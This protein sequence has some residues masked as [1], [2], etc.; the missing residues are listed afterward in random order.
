MIE[1]A[2]TSILDYG[3]DPTGS[4]DSTVA[5]QTAINVVGNYT[6]DTGIQGTVYIPNGS[7]KITAPI[8]MG[9][10]VMLVGNG[11]RFA[12]TFVPAAT[13][14][15]AALFQIN[16]ALMIG[17]FAFYSSFKNLTVDLVNVTATEVPITFNFDFAY[18]CTIEDVYV[19]Q[20][21]GTIISITGCNDIHIIRPRIFGFQTSDCDFGIRAVSDA[22]VTITSPDLELCNVGI[23]QETN[24]RVTVL[25]GYGERNVRAWKNSGSTAGSM[26]V[27]GGIWQGVNAGTIAAEALGGN[28][29][30]IG[31]RYDAN[32]GNGLSVGLSGTKPANVQF[33]GVS[34]DITDPKNWATTKVVADTPGIHKTALTNY[35]QVTDAVA[36]S[37]VRVVCP[38]AAINWGTLKLRV[39][40]KLTSTGFTGYVGTWNMAFGV[41]GAVIQTG[42]L[43]ESDAMAYANS[44]N[45]S[46]SIAMTA[47]NS[48]PNL[49][50][51]VTADS[52]GALGN[53][54][55][56]EIMVEAELTQATN[57]GAVYM[58]IQ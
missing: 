18:S 31:G 47:V 34:G 26:T 24:C 56:V 32:G 27:I 30:V 54:D 58:I 53:G 10:N 20:G 46:L 38:N 17:G 16:G 5:I 8:I 50:I 37:L 28:C 40:A 23:S 43:V 6:N 57:T 48:I 35:K 3:A 49:D 36:T 12:S 21:V 45:Y 51:Q 25:G 19:R 15:G 13:F 4:A 42:A 44:P 2:V 55:T 1:G 14:S 9:K 22:S 41:S 29:T 39:S 7:Y 11:L 52:G 33:L